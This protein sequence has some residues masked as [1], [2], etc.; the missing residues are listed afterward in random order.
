MAKKPAKRGSVNKRKATGGRGAGRRRTT[1]N[2]G[3][4][5]G[6]KRRPARQR[7]SILLWFLKWSVVAGIWGAVVVAGVVAWFSFGLPQIDRLAVEGRRPGVVL[8]AVDGT[9]LASFGD[10]YGARRDVSELPSHLP[11]AVVAIEDRRFYNHPGVDL[12]GVARAFVVNITR[13]RISQGASTLTQQLAKNLFLTPERTFSRKI[14]ELILAI[15]LERR[16]T[17]DE[18][19]TIYLNQVYMGAG[20]YGVEAAS[21]RYFQRSAR[22]IDVYQSAILAGLLRAPS[23][24]N[25]ANDPV[26]AHDRALTVLAA[27]TGAGFI[28]SDQAAAAAANGDLS[29]AANRVSDGALYFADWVLPQLAGFVG[30]AG[31]D[32]VVETTLDPGLQRLAERL[33]KVTAAETGAQAALL[34][35]TPDGAVRAMVGGVDYRDSQFNRAAQAMRQPGSAFKPFVYLAALE[36]GMTPDT[37]LQDAPITIGDWSPRNAGDSYLGAVS[38][39]Q[40]LA[41]SLNSVA[42]RVIEQVGPRQV[43]DV[44]RRTGIASDLAPNPS[45]AL[46]AS[47]VTPLELATAYAVFAN[48]GRGVI[49]HGIREI[50]DADAAV[51]FRR[52]GGGL[53]RVIDRDHLATMHA[54]LSAVVTDGTGRA[55]RLDRPAAGK[56]GTSQESRDAWFVGYT[57]DLVTAVW[58]GHDDAR[59]MGD[60]V[61]GGAPARLWRDFMQ[62]AHQGVPARPLSGG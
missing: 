15:R 61:G 5:R 59:S 47:E 54:L 43:I 48:G 49:N 51:L 39:R 45:L 44:A 40:A 1:A 58:I 14:R 10:N 50:R 12:R 33:V 17:K 8:V 46:G 23:R 7:P 35:M 36:S 9:R 6:A 22:D 21:Q 25:P 29:R 20:T 55:A 37:V 30:L 26:G 62:A 13:G 34:A 3:R 16:F 60:V 56:T 41:D 4:K 38:L 57:A 19:L 24:W 27:M 53:G 28:T 18:L 31:G 52:D 42:V 2:R 32:V 11:Q